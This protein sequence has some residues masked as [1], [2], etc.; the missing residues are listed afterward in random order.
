MSAERDA[1]ASADAR[2]L[3]AASCNSPDASFAA[4]LADAFAA[5]SPEVQAW[6]YGNAPD[7]S[8][9]EGFTTLGYRSVFIGEPASS[10]SDVGEIIVYKTA[11]RHFVL[12]T[13]MA[14]TNE[15][16]FAHMGS[17]VTGLPFSGQ[18]RRRRFAVNMGAP[19]F[20]RVEVAALA[21]GARITH[22]RC[23]AVTEGGT[24]GI[25]Q[26][27]ITW[28]HGDAVVPGR[29]AAASD[30][31]LRLL[32]R[33]WR[34]REPCLACAPNG[35][36]VP[37]PCPH[38][39]NRVVGV[40]FGG[41][42]DFVRRLSSRTVH[43][44]AHW[45]LQQ[46]ALVLAGERPPVIPTT[47]ATGREAMGTREEVDEPSSPS[48]LAARPADVPGALV[49]QGGG[50]D[51]P[52]VALD[53]VDYEFRFFNP[54]EPLTYFDSLRQSLE[55]SETEPVGEAH[56]LGPPAGTTGRRLDTAATGGESSSH[57]RTSNPR[58]S[59]RGGAP[60]TQGTTPVTDARPVADSSALAS[61]TVLAAEGAPT[62]GG[63]LLGIGPLTGGA[64]AGGGGCGGAVDG[65]R[66]S[67]ATA[68]AVSSRP[69][70]GT[71][72]AVWVDTHEATVGSSFATAPTLQWLPAPSVEWAGYHLPAAAGSSTA[73]LSTTTPMFP[74]T[75]PG[76]GAPSVLPPP[77]RLATDLNPPL[78]T[79][80]PS[81]EAQLL[82]LAESWSMPHDV[83]IGAPP[84]T[85]SA[86][87]APLS[88]SLP[89]SFRRPPHDASH[90]SEP[91]PRPRPHACRLCGSSFLA[92]SDLARHV[93]TVHHR[94]RRWQCPSCQ[95]Q[96]LQKGHLTTHI[97]SVHATER[98]YV[99]PE[100]PPGP[101]AFRGVTRSAV[102]RHTRRVHQGLRPYLC[103]TCGSSFASTSDL[104]RHRRRVH[105]A[106]ISTRSEALRQREQA[107]AAA[108]AVREAAAAAV[109]AGSSSASGSAEAGAPCVSGGSSSGSGTAAS[110]AQGTGPR[111]MA[112]NYG[113]A[114]SAPTL[115]GAIAN[116]IIAAQG[117]GGAET[118][119]LGGE[120]DQGPSGIPI[121][122]EGGAWS[123]ALA[124]LVYPSLDLSPPLP[125]ASLGVGLPHQGGQAA[126][127]TAA[128][129]GVVARDSPLP[130]AAVDAAAAAVTAGSSPVTTDVVAATCPPPSLDVALGDADLGAPPDAA[131]PSGVVQ[132]RRGGTDPE[133]P[134]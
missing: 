46:P 91:P 81:I 24:G 77:S 96:G 6:L 87:T 8:T 78:S 108:A 42:E 88:Q 39:V 11:T 133:S 114:L 35:E 27:V 22:E 71:D 56:L 117:H 121:L 93:E 98:R 105:Q 99:C 125:D 85:R 44:T 118:R 90:R 112:P 126:A 80:I 84:S 113:A 53:P 51:T 61:G 127:P 20:Q 74:T 82:S 60:R 62:D 131:R 34:R 40:T 50:S 76:P 17:Q 31:A 21:D 45:E 30:A 43:G 65:G 18:A 5:A 66:S 109:R 3:V 4:G 97:A 120:A 101:T 7:C 110:R 130:T 38:E 68:R 115:M 67:T 72:A 103:V 26:E 86:P 41:W 15:H 119:A 128:V 123:A 10:L 32:Q 36:A 129:D 23:L 55:A 58:A 104:T 2:Q 29:P 37:Q 28:H 102:Q 33:P 63:G 16:P 106:V 13:V 64:D 12:G 1:A 52:P 111:Y 9:P 57:P 70:R 116:P 132:R 73:Q 100:C 124:H 47:A 122:D 83:S 19:C 14:A 94:L 95:F 134:S 75:A 69:A 49:A 48:A 107:T 92:Q 25:Y 79:A 89:D 59:R 54:V